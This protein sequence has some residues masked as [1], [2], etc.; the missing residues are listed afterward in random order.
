M[1]KTI[2][3]SAAG[4]STP[5]RGKLR[6][7]HFDIVLAIA[8]FGSLSKA[9]GRLH[10]TQS[11]LSRAIAEIE[12]IVGGRLFERTG[13]GMVCTPLGD[14]LCRHAQV[15][16]GD[17]DHAESDLDAIA[18]GNLGSLTLGCFSLFSGW[19]L[20]RAVRAFQSAH[21]RVAL[22][23]HVG[24]H[25]T[26]IEDLDAGRLDLLISR[27]AP[28]LNPD[29]YRH[30][31]LL[32]DRVVLACAP[33]HPLASRANVAL[34]DCLASPWIV[35]P[36]KNRVRV[37]LEAQLQAW[38]VAA[39]AF[40]GALSLEFSLDLIEDGTCL[41]LLPSSVAGHLARRRG[42]H[43]LPLDLGLEAPPLAAIWRRERSS[44]LQMRAFT[45]LLQSVIDGGI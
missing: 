39:P 1:P 45:G 22:S 9:A 27:R 3:L 28:T 15:L 37:E 7:R 43:I 26:L 35:P 20:A 34:A 2:D 6:F 8:D 25:N 24:M 38:G 17:L 11:G 42:L 5:L 40:I 44:T 13:K 31:D 32:V 12:E 36:P 29:T 41:W 18:K 4:M 30:T 21:P 33:A 16:L 23:V 10:L 14:A 19:P